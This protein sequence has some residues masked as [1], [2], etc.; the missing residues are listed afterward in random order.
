[1][2]P[3]KIK[4]VL[5]IAVALIAL[6]GMQTAPAAD[7]HKATTASHLQSSTQKG[8][9]IKCQAQFSKQKESGPMYCNTLLKASKQSHTATLKCIVGTV[10]QYNPCRCIILIK[11]P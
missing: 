5:V 2:S 6:G 4:Q 7:E 9:E 10:N 11:L 3:I 8:C 1:M